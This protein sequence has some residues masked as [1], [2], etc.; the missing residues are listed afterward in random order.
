MNKKEFPKIK[1]LP[2]SR[3]N[4]P[5]HR[6]HA[7]NGHVY[8][9]KEIFKNGVCPILYHTLYPYFLGALYGAKFTYNEQ[10]DCHVC[11]PAEKGIDVLVKVRPYDK[12]FGDEV[13]SDWRDV[14]HAEV[15]KV[16]G[17]CDYNHKVG[18]RF[19]FPT[20]TKTDFIC[21]AGVNNIFPFLDVP[22]PSCINTKK[23]R[24]PDWLEDIYYSIE[25]EDMQENK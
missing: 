1:Q 25:E 12:G 3:T 16:N 17:E 21:P 19:V 15:V 18:D 8:K 14:I 5:W 20:C 4:C 7:K 11:C 23:L 13:P 10:G 6:H 24:C 2:S 22:I 9:N